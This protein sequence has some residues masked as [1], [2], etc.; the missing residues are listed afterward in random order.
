MVLRW[1]APTMFYVTDQFNNRVVKFSSNGTFLTQ[2]SGLGIGN[3]QFSGPFGIAVDN[4]NNVYV[5]DLNNNRIEEFHKQW[6]VPDTV[7]QWGRWQRSI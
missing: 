2:W 5:A 7:G 1:I 6:N 4:G 3:G